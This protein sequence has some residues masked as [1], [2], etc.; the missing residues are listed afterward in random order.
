MFTAQL[1]PDAIKQVLDAKQ[2]SQNWLAFRLRIT[3]GYMSQLM[4]GTRSPSAR[5]RTR[6]L[7]RLGGE[8]DDWFEIT[9][10]DGSPSSGSH[11]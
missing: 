6:I 5:L 2:K 8:F 11:S 4:A 10:V 1:K 9:P 7:E 3:S